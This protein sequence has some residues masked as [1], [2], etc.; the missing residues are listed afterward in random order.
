[1]TDVR[2]RHFAIIGALA[3]ILAIGFDPF[4]QNLIHYYQHSVED[5]GVPAY[6]ASSSYY[7]TVGPLVGG[8]GMFISFV[9]FEVTVIYASHRIL[10]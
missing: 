3:T 10:Y 9:H 8:S 4:N 5:T 6:L 2:A 7:N 1:M